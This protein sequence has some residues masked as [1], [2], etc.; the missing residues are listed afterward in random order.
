MDCQPVRR[1]E[2]W[3]EAV[4]PTR[5]RPVVVSSSNWWNEAGPPVIAVVPIASC[6]GASATNL[7]VPAGMGGLAN[8]GVLQ[9][10]RLRYVDSR[11]LIAP[12]GGQL[13]YEIMS[14]LRDVLLRTL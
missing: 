1:G 13:S 3:W 10:E 2:L 14:K 12:I 8:R 9:P 5:M 11:K 7:E 4:E 6:D